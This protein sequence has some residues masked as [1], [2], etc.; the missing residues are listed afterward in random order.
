[1]SARVRPSLFLS[2]QRP[3]RAAGVLTALAGVAAA[4]AVVYPLKHVAPVVSLG[5]VYVLA[6]VVVSMFW[7]LA[8]GVATAVLSVAAFSFF[9]LPPV[10]RFTLAD[11]GNWIG[12]SAFVVVAAAT[13]LLADLARARAREADQRRREADLAAKLAQLLLGATRLQ[14]ALVLAAQRL[15]A[16]VGVASAAIELGRVEADGRVLALALLSDGTQVGTLLLPATLSEAERSWVVHR[17]VP[18]L[19]SI[20][21]AAL[22]RTE[23]QAEVVET[24]AL[25]RSDEM[26]TA[27]L[28]SVSH[29][30]R[31][32]VT[33]ILTA[34]GTLDPERPTRENVA[35]VRELVM[36][37]ATR[38]WLLI[39]KLLDLSL[40]QAGQLEPRL[41][42]YS[43]EEVLHEAVEQTGRGEV[44]R[45]S[46]DR[47]LPLL[48]GDPAQLERA[49]A[50]V[51]EN[52]VRYSENKPVSV[53]ARAVAGRV[54]VR[55]VDQ[56]PG[57]HASEY[58]RVF[59][60]FYRSEDGGGH[61]GSGLGLAIAKGFVEVNGGRI[62]VESAPGQGTSFVIDFPLADSELTTGR[63]EA[64]EPV[65]S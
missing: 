34:A 17:V 59:L 13:G 57:I 5:V 27:V 19:E 23:L 56:G 42:W 51:L 33:T 40:L 15:A 38:L 62:A 28:R 1:M 18:S 48:R 54:R 31:T 63:P 25:R 43:I 36:D 2:E 7:G 44:F 53:R 4:T 30:L 49:F 60:P 16:A 24:A 11:S 9:H 6:V 22:H 58:E 12:L 20:L 29:D 45:V 8:Y 10:G 35:E 61:H 37:S 39:E 26:K 50:N 47:D 46:V 65:G 14:D 32:P 21:A 52:G 3:S 64:A 41:G 55:V